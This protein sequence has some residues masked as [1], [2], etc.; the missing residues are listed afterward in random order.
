MIHQISYKK[1]DKG[2]EGMGK[3]YISQIPHTVIGASSFEYS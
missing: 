2:G 1:G 3:Y